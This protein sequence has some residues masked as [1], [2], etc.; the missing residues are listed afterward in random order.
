MY[1]FLPQIRKY[2]LK[3]F[4]CNSR[5]DIKTVP[6]REFINHLQ[7]QII[8]EE[9]SIIEIDHATQTAILSFNMEG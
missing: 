1:E 8:Q 9:S 5:T 4:Y 3:L 6:K 2:Q 7:D